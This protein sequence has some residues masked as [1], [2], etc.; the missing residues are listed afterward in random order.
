M[1]AERRGGDF[2]DDGPGDGSDS[3]LV[4]EGPD[5]HENDLAPDGAGRGDERYDTD[6]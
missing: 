3:R 5:S 2:G 6:H 4:S 1:G